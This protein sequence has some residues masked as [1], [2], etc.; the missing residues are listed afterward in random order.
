[1]KH[2]RM[3]GMG[4]N[5]NLTNSYSYLDKALIGLLYL[6]YNVPSVLFFSVWISTS[7][8]FEWPYIVLS[9]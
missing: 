1:M 4:S 9:E 2:G 3:G 6:V 5:K 7:L 8:G